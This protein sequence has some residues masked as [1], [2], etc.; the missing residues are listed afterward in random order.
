M[1]LTRR[2]SSGKSYVLCIQDLRKS[3]YIP[4][5]GVLIKDTINVE[6]WVN[7][8]R[9]VENFIPDITS[10]ICKSVC[11]RKRKRALRRKGNVFFNVSRILAALRSLIQLIQEGGAGR[12]RFNIC[13]MGINSS[14]LKEK[15]CSYLWTKS[16]AGISSCTRSHE[17]RAVKCVQKVQ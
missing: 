16:T 4:W 7:Y 13:Y 1:P 12:R 17:I 9:G 14:Y 2:I 10:R 6:C 3:E 11:S 15:T 8:E 5:N